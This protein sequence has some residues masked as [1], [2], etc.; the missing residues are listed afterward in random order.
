MDGLDAI[1]SRQ[2]KKQATEITLFK[3]IWR[4]ISPWAL[5]AVGYVALL[6]IP[7]ILYG[8]FRHFYYETNP[9]FTI[10]P[11]D[12]VIRGNSTLTREMILLTFGL[13]QPTNGFALVRSKEIVPRLRHGMP[14]LKRAQM[15]YEPQRSIELWV[16][17]RAPVARLAGT[18]RPP[19]V[20]DEEGVVFMYSR[21]SGGY[22]EIGGFDIPEDLAEPGAQ[23]PSA[24]NC[25]LHLLVAEQMEQNKLPSNIR[26]VRLIG[27]DPEDGLLVVLA[28]G[29]RITIAWQA[30]ERAHAITPYMIERLR[31]LNRQLGVLRPG[32]TAIA[33][34]QRQVIEQD[35]AEIG[36][37]PRMIE[38][39]QEVG[40]VLRSPLSEGK[41]YFNA[42][43][44]K[45]VSASE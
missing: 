36:W 27:S 23:L 26:S 40:C 22:P 28:D 21:P 29:R 38:Q 39:L 19:L 32:H 42:T 8:A 11:Q 7:F 25:M 33:T 20:V 44:P 41:K 17:E 5:T 43:V 10:H 3:K 45:R 30:M 24:L 18:S 2:K 31:E 14:I 35:L 12:I 37:S 15:T 13:T 34:A 16:E 1:H 6:S 4:W 9:A